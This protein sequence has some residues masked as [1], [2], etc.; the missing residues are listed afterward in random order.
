MIEL[1]DVLNVVV[2][3]AAIA[4]VIRTVVE[5]LKNAGYIPA[6]SAGQVQG[7]INFVLALAVF[8]A[9]YFGVELEST[10]EIQRALSLAPGVLELT[11]FVVGVAFTK[12]AHE[13]LKLA[14]VS[15]VK[16]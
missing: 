5:G 8:V 13:I 2:T 1:Q 6:G 16:E 9:G 14:G 3:I 4:V 15:G 10:A 11:L 7:V 12:G